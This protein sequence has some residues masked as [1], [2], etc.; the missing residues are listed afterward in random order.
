[1]K[2]GTKILLAVVAVGIVLAFYFKGSS[3]EGLKY[4][5]GFGNALKEARSS[6]KPIL[7]NFGGPW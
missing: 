6:E 4:V 2:S 1:M 5:G 7:L 3:A